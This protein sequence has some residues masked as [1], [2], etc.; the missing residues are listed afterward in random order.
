MKQKGFTL[1]ELLV[2]LPIGALLLAS[3]VAGVFL[4]PRGTIEVRNST[5]ALADLENIAHWLNRDIVM[6]QET[7]MVAGTQ[8]VTSVNVSWNDYTGGPGSSIAHY[9]RYYTSGTQLLREYDGAANFTIAGRNL[10]Y[11]GFSI[12][13]GGLVTVNLT[14]SPAGPR[15]KTISRSYNIQILGIQ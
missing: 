9:V 12:N 3:I 14:T 1:V 10:S 6:G 8:P 15:Q 5:A 4:I 2:A 11:V 7:S 13:S